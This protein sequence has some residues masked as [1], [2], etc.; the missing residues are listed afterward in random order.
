MVGDILF[1]DAEIAKNY[2]QDVLHAHAAS[3]PLHGSRGKPD[4][5]GDQLFRT[6]CSQLERGVQSCFGLLKGHT[7]A[8]SRDQ[9]RGGGEEAL[10]ESANGLNQ[11]IDPRPGFCRYG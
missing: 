4:L 2:I 1:A 6:T 10:A 8:L 5:F 7:V 11:G 3:Q 9:H